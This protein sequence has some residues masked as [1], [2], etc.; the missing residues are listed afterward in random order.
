[1]PCLPACSY[2]G[3]TSESKVLDK[4]TDVLGRL[5]AVDARYDA[6]VFYAAGYDPP[7][8]LINRHN[9]IWIPA[10]PVSR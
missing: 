5:D 6:S 2:P 4:A 10:T 8:R 7:F 1:M 9:E 3:F